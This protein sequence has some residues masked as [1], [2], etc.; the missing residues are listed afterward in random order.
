MQAASPLQ[1]HRLAWL[2]QAAWANTLAATPWDEP[3]QACLSHWH[4]QRLPLVVARQPEVGRAAAAGP[5]RIHLGLAMPQ[6]W[7]RGR[8]SIAVEPAGIRACGDFPTMAAVAD[9]M[10]PACRQAWQALTA[11]LRREGC[12]ARVYGSFGWQWLSKL[13]YV[14]PTS[15]VDVLL[16]VRDAEQ[17][18]RV[19]ACLSAW[20]GEAQGM[21]RLDGELAGPDHGA[22][23]WRE[24]QRWRNG[25]AQAMLVKRIDGV[26]LH[27]Q[28]W[29]PTAT[30]LINPQGA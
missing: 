8:L 6:Q 1:R 27:S 11:A 13:A 19:V 3:A 25:Q 12:E 17:A 5:Q 16:P 26:Q 23:P 29:W 14:R 30:P 22:V 9:L 15:D 10:P 7:G 28:P 18:D 24:W 21:P 4:R 2:T 20:P